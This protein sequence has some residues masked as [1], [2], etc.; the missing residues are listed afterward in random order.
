MKILVVG[1][2]G[3]EHALVRA[4]AES[5]GNHELFCF[6]GSDAIFQ[7]AK[8]VAAD[9]LESLIAWMRERAID[10]CVAGEESYLVKG[11][12]LANLC[13]K[14]GIPCWGPP[15]ESAQLEASKEFAKQFLIRN[16]IPTARA[17]ATDTLV[18][19][20]SAIA[21]EYPTVLKFDGLAAGKGVAVCP[22]ETSALAFLDEVFTQRRF[23]PGRVLVEQCLTGPEVSVF[24]AIVDETYLIFTP[25]RDYKRA[26]D[27]DHGPNTGG[28]GAVASRQLVSPELL[29]QIENEIV[30]PTVAG[31]NK[32]GLPYRGFLYFGLMLTPGGPQVIEYNCRFG[33]P[34]CQAVMPLVKGDLASFCLAGANGEL[35]GDLV[36]FD[37]GWSVCVILASAGYPETS[38]SGDVISG[39]EQSGDFRVYHAGTRKN[40]DGDWETNGG[41]VLAIV[42][43]AATRPEAVAKAHAAADLIRFSG[44]QRR[45][46]IGILNF[47]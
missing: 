2:G 47:D 8:P 21:G 1:K 3:R 40:A 17:R 12:G 22:D 14:H 35:R 33:D 43:G 38:R 23:G 34:E 37:D 36:S 11:E 4:L 6:P 20:V 28:M 13:R 16:G 41:R 42:S 24:A 44:L 10:L 25:A 7:L 18:Q 9:G 27:G 32:E 30:R 19:A 26:L 5:P 31:L 46:D 45:R 29:Q 39:L 15:K